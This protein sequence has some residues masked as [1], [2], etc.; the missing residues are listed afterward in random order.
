MAGWQH[1]R[2]AGLPGGGGRRQG[3][4]WAGGWLAALSAGWLAGGRRQARLTLMVWAVVL[5]WWL[6]AGWQLCR[7]A[8]LPGAEAGETDING[9][10]GGTGLVAGWL[11]GW[12]LAGST[13]G[14]LACLGAEA[15][16]T[17][18]NGLG[19]GTGLVA[20]W[21]VAAAPSAG[22]LAGG[23]RQARLTLM[24]GSVGLGRWLGGWLA[25]HLW[26]GR[27]CRLAGLPGGGG[28]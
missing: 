28:R 9:L 21:L 26:S 5:G 7:L 2:L 15:G 24:V 8:G 4:D 6:V 3:W 12:W 19:G 27:H 13:V 23:Q 1:C 17:D 18:I 11:G 22:W 25:A 10:G 14:W 20:G 16:E